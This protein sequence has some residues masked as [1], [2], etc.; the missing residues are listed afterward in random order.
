MYMNSSKSILSGVCLIFLLFSI[1]TQTAEAGTKCK[2]EKHPAEAE[3]IG[4][5]SRTEDPNYCTLVYTTTPEEE[6]KA[7][8]DRLQ[9]LGLRE[10]P[11]QI[12]RM[13]YE[14]PPQKFGADLLRNTL[15]IL[16]AISQRR[17]FQDV[18][19]EVAKAFKQP[20]NE[21]QQAYQKEGKSVTKSKIGSFDAIISY[22]CIELRRG[23]LVTM[24]KT[25]WSK[26][27]F[28]CNDFTE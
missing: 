16:F 27:N 19:P 14:V 26:A 11:R 6:Y 20:I 5:C 12:L 28:F 9:K 1:I 8:V 17:H 24:V 15:T 3:A 7:F 22:G 23:N 13:A 25:R 2:C 4:T 21:I 10:D 18:T